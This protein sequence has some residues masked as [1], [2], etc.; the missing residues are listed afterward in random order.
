MHY[1]ESNA[2]NSNARGTAYRIM[3]V[4]RV[5]ALFLVLKFAFVDQASHAYEGLFVSPEL[6]IFTLHVQMHGPFNC[7]ISDFCERCVIF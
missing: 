3:D 7:S 6:Q 1:N 5:G 4:I 2:A